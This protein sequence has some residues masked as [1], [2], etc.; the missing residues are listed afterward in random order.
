MT[1]MEAQLVKKIMYA[2]FDSIMTQPPQRYFSW[3]RDALTVA[4]IT[5]L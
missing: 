3:K 4:T 1:A 2:T 5:V